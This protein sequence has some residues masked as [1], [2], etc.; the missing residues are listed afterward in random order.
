MKEFIKTFYSKNFIYNGKEKLS[1]LTITFIGLLNIFIFITLG[2]GIDFQIKVLN[3]PSVIFPYECREI[4]NNEN[5]DDFNNYFYVLENDNE[6]YKEIKNLEIDSRCN[7]ILNAKIDSVKKEHNIKLMK[8][9]EKQLIKNE[10]SINDEL[11]YIRE[12]YNTI[13]FE[14]LS[15][16]TIDKSIIKDNLSSQNI[17]EKYNSYQKQFEEIKKNKEK[18]YKKFKESKSVKDFQLYVNENKKQINLDIKKFNK[19]YSLKKE[20]VSLAFLL[21]LIFVFFYLMKRYLTKEKYILYIIFKNIFIVTMIPTIIS[22]IS[23]IYILLPK[24]F[25][26]KV[27]MFFYEIEIPF[28]MYYFVITIFIFVFGFTIIKLQK[29]FKEENSK[30]KNNRITKVESYNKGVCNNCGN[31]VDFNTMNFCPSCQNHLKIECKICN[32]QTIKD[33]DYCFNCGNSIKEIK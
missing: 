7:I 20:L 24:I 23:F 27:L 8:S 28:I 14:K 18:L 21:P 31:R 22:F 4:V 5:I 15:S 11:N 33:L 29:R 10:N 13:L 6:Q 17:K 25:I 2:L 19:E 1:K 9:E 12:N 26:E 3:N 30:L 16:Q 32:E